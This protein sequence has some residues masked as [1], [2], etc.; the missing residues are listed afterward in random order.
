MGCSLPGSSVHGIFQATGLEWIAISFSRGSSQPRDQTR[1]SRVVDR[2]FTVGYPKTQERSLY[3]FNESFWYPLAFSFPIMPLWKREMVNRNAWGDNF[4]RVV[5][6]VWVAV[7]LQGCGRTLGFGWF[8]PKAISS[9][10]WYHWLVR[11]PVRNWNGNWD[12]D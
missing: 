10:S 1:V 7:W 6:P 5:L 2:R 9:W 4:P 3:S 8:C 12:F 11:L